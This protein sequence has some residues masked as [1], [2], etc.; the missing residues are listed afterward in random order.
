MVSTY[1]LPNSV[2]K[3]CDTE[4]GPCNMGLYTCR[5]DTSDGSYGQC[6][7]GLCFTSTQGDP[8]FP[9]FEDDPL[10]EDQIICSCPITKANLGANIGYQI[11]GPFPCEEEFFNNCSSEFTNDS[12]GARIP[13][14]SPTGS[15]KILALLLDGPSLPKLNECGSSSFGL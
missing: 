6:D 8:S 3:K 13:V 10:E 9:G 1:S 14:G 7:G 11:A 4:E 12:L 15:A 2:V 5:G